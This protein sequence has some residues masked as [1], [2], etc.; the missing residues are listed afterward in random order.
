MELHEPPD[1]R[2]GSGAIIALALLSPVV[3]VVVGLVAA[4]R[5]PLMFLTTLAPVVLVALLLLLGVGRWLRSRATARPLDHLVAVVPIVA[6][7]ATLMVLLGAAQRFG[8]R[9]SAVPRISEGT[10]MPA[11]LPYVAAT[12]ACLAAITVA[13]VLLLVLLTSGL[14]SPRSADG[15]VP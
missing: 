12:I 8:I 4:Y 5:S 13:V 7:G 1:P 9:G 10:A 14:R 15:P 11:D 2:S 3:P 6:V